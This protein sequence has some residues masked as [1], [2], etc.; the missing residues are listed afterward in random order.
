MLKKPGVLKMND[1]LT[2]DV[3]QLNAELDGLWLLQKMGFTDEALYREGNTV[4]V[5]CP[6]HKDQVRRSLIIDLEKREFRCQYAECEA[7]AGGLLVEFYA[8]FMDIDLSQ[9][10]EHLFGGEEPDKELSQKADELIQEGKLYEA[11]PLLEKALKIRPRNAITR[12]KLAALYLELGKRE[13]GIREYFN[14]AE[15]FGV[16]GELQKTLSIYNILIILSPVDIKVHKRLAYLYTRLGE[17]HEAVEQLKWVVNKLIEDNQLK[18]AM[19]ECHEMLALDPDEPSVYEILGHVLIKSGRMVDGVAALERSSSLYLKRREKSRAEELAHEA[20]RYVPHSA[21][22]QDLLAQARA[23]EESEIAKDAEETAKEAEF[24]EWVKGLEESISVSAP[25][26]EPDTSEV[27]AT[28]RRVFLCKETL[29]GLD[30]EHIAALHKHLVNMFS[31]VQQTY[32]GGLLEKWELKT[33]KEFYKA[34]C[35][36]LEQYK[37]EQGITNF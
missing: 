2:E 33:V 34:F 20:L 26:Q 15:D 12:C 4:R 25:V 36:A 24:A 32:E 21:A 30:K 10:R 28:D 3:R 9:V 8:R 22:L 18:K 14:A 17:R 19:E 37:K 1:S 23:S 7:R 16:L 6:I 27:L 35:I 5:F 11:L 31:E 29:K 13:Q